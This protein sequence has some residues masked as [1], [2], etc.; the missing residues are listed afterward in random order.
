MDPRIAR[1]VALRPR[2]RAQE[3]LLEQS[4]HSVKRP[5]FQRR[6]RHLR[7][8]PTA[9]VECVRFRSDLI[10]SRYHLPKKPSGR[11]RVHNL[12]P[13][14]HSS[15]MEGLSLPSFPDAPPPANLAHVCGERPYN[16]PLSDP[17]SRYRNGIAPACFDKAKLSLCQ[18]SAILAYGRCP[19][20]IGS[21]HVAPCSDRRECSNLFARGE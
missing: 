12:R 14:H 4:G 15:L 10:R 19:R 17:N 21:R 1:L 7:Q 20:E 13:E 9:A 2:P 8:A 16:M 5:E 3:D 18:I 11:A 6:E